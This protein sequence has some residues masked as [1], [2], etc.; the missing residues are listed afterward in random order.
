VWAVPTE[1]FTRPQY[2][3]YLN[4]EGISV[5]WTPAAHSGS[6]SIVFFRRS[7]V[8]VTGNVVDMT[9]FP[10]IDIAHGGS[11]QGELA[12]LNRLVNE[13]VLPPVPLVT[14][15]GSTLVIPARGPLCNQADLVTYRDM[16]AVVS[17]RIRDQIDR[18]MSLGQVERSDPTAGYDSR[19]GTDTG[20][21]TTR[22]FIDAVYKSLA[23]EK[24]HG[25]KKT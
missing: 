10:V 23:A 16:V 24:K 14:D 18:G 3:F 17:A 1:T 21:W 11:V 6:D 19:F 20:D 15:F 5:V 13:F 7:D 12:A 8:V 4:G 9:R 25:K 22:N 2:N